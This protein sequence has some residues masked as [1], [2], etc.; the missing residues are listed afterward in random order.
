LPPA[1]RRQ[2]AG[3]TGVA[4]ILDYDNRVTDTITNIQRINSKSFLVLFFKKELLS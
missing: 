2:R 1:C 3:A 4:L